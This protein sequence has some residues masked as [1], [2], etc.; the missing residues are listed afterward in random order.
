MFG[1]VH[2]SATPDLDNVWCAVCAAKGTLWTKPAVIHNETGARPTAPQLDLVIQSK[3]ATVFA[4]AAGAF[5]QRVSF[6][7]HWKV[8]F[9]DLYRRGL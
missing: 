8:L 7:E 5:P 9:H 2:F 4:F 6:V 3:T 1:R